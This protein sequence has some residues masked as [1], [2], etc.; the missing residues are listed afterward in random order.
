MLCSGACTVETRAC[1]RRGWG[2]LAQVRTAQEDPPAGVP[3]TV[4]RVAP[5]GCVYVFLP[6]PSRD[7]P[8]SMDD[9]DTTGSP[10][11]HP[12]SYL[13][14]AVPRTASGANL[15][16]ESD[17][18]G[19]PQ[20]DNPTPQL[21][22][23]PTH[24][25]SGTIGE[26]H[27]L[28]MVRA[29]ARWVQCSGHIAGRG[30]RPLWSRPPRVQSVCGPNS[31]CDPFPSQVGLPA[32]GKTHMAKRLERYLAFF[33][34][35]RT[36]VFNVGEYRRRAESCKQHAA[37]APPGSSSSNSGFFNPLDENAARERLNFA[38]AAVRDMVDFLFQGEDVTPRSSG[39]ESPL[40]KASGRWSELRS[41]SPVSG[42]TPERP[43]RAV[44]SGRV[45]IF[46][47]TNSTRKRRAWL[48][49]QLAHLPIKLLFVESMCTDESIVDNNIR[50]AKVGLPEFSHLPV[51]EAFRDFK[52]RIKHY[53]SVYEPMDEEELAWIKLINCG[54]RVEINNIH[55]YLLGR[56]VQFL[57]NM[58][59][60]VHSIYLSRHGQSEY[61]RVGKIGGDSPL[62]VA[63]EAYAHKLAAFVQENVC[64]DERGELV[65]TRLWTSSL[66]RTIQTARYI[67]H[68]KLVHPDGSE[69]VQ[70]APRV[71]R[72]LDEIYAG[73]CD[74]MTYSEIECSYPEE[75][76]MRKEDK[77]GYRYPRGES[78]LDV[79]SRL[80]PLIHELESY[81]EPVLIVGHQA[82]LRLIYAYF[83]G[84]P[85]E[86]C[87]RL[88]IPLNTIIKLTPRTHDCEEQRITLDLGLGGD[89]LLDDTGE[90]PSH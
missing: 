58:H 26:K 22:P 49:E 10:S 76:A 57:A 69:W 51:E 13:Q 60:T 9:I 35:A 75:Y 52:A 73:V 79:I 77:L 41:S 42:A 65:K 7:V 81:S 1:D 33:H 32:R 71:M 66:Q 47:A 5:A 21:V 62:S 53:E 70:M 38:Q 44:D 19:Q 27:V 30:T 34:G 43:M 24:A 86:A 36:K 46:D 85:R 68:P 63:G 17:G 18:G 14:S 15:L 87:P 88:S 2:A 48:R 45:A 55:G 16:R 74:G 3:P 64:K 84:K 67:P 89:A 28:V 31:A 56:I 54:R 82:V 72:N 11:L 6:L 4:T 23:P 20:R 12:A 83:T 8:L 61:N 59:N 37:A 39:A 25:V 29:R 78:Y 50:N 80:D 90:P 40:A